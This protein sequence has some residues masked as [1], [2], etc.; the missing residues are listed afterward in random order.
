[1]VI[2]LDAHQVSQNKRPVKRKLKYLDSFLK[3]YYIFQR[4]MDMKETLLETRKYLSLMYLTKIYIQ[5]T[6]M[7]KVQSREL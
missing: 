7:Q 6:H 4:V 2:D 5:K 3:I 1:M